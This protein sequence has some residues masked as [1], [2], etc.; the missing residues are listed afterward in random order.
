M[1]PSAEQIEICL[2]RMYRASGAHAAAAEQYGHYAAVMR[3]DLG[4]DPP[5]LDSL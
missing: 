5:P 4:L 1:D 2:L 3:E